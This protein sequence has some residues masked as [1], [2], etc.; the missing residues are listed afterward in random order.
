MNR[1][2]VL[3]LSECRFFDALGRRISKEQLRSHP[4]ATVVT[5][6]GNKPI[7]E[8]IRLEGNKYILY[9]PSNEEI[10]CKIV[11]TAEEPIVAGAPISKFSFSLADYKGEKVYDFPTL[12]WMKISGINGNLTMCGEVN[13]EYKEFKVS[14]SDI[15]ESG[16]KS[17]NKFYTL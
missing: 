15:N 6:A 12:I 16:F 9:T 14:F 7:C 17:G 3:E 10:E 13:S 11:S 2:E 1:L 8:T 4:I 5:K